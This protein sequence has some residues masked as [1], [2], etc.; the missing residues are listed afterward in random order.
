[1]KNLAKLRLATQAVHAGRP[2]E[3]PDFVPTVAPIHPSVTYRYD[4]MDDLDAVF[5]GTKQG[6][7][8]TRY[9][10]PTVTALEEAVATLEQGEAAL[11]YASGMA[12][13]HAGLLASGVQAGTAVV[14]AQDVYG[15]TYALLDGL[16]RD[17]GVSTR[18]VDA[19]HLHAVETACAE[20]RPVALIVETLSNPLLK[21][22]DL[23]ALA[24][25]AHQHG[26]TFLVDN[27][28]ATPCLVQPLILGAD[29]VIHSATKYLGGHGDV[30]GGVAV[31]SNLRRTE[32]LEVQK[33]TGG[34]L[35]PQ[36]AWLALRGI[37]TLPLRMRQHCTNA[38]EVAHWLEEH[39]RVRRVNYPGLP[40]HPQH[41]LATGLFGDRGY[42]GMLS[43][44]LKGAD[45]S[46]VFRFFERL[47]LCLPV[48]TL[49]DV[50]TL[51][52]Y[53]AHSSHRAISPEERARIGIGDGLVRVSVGIEAVEDIVADLDQ[54]L[55]E[56]EV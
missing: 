44:E 49:G 37:R 19:A 52:M 33:L 47:R 2:A 25:L 53:P 23:A 22:A 56:L 29:I 40:S 26:A 20:S 46:T 4:C 16:L 7:V 54:A 34:N 11:G 6:Y 32:M 12:A 1:M 35:G 45:Q 55:G 3:V 5:A 9:G 21:I 42:G 28:F 43:F 27:T 41:A 38:M 13:I 30:L 17:Q 31:T 39:P 15:A 24:D 8:Y 18:F 10:S 14:A 48:T 50:Y 51:V 36:E